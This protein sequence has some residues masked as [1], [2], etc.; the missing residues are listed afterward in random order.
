MKLQ[1]IFIVYLDV[2]NYQNPLW[3]HCNETK[4]T[5]HDHMV[6]FVLRIAM[7]SYHFIGNRYHLTV[8]HIF[9]EGKFTAYAL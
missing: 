1:I 2:A 9:A 5:Y 7:A 4:S 3:T 8:C 6:L